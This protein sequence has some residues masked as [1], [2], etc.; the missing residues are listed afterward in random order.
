ME[1]G[2]GKVREKEEKEKTFK[3]RI[4]EWIYKR[5]KISDEWKNAKE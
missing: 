1:R 5:A 2:K 3:V 4:I